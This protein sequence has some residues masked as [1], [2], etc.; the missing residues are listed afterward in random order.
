MTNKLSSKPFGSSRKKTILRNSLFS[1]KRSF[2]EHDVA[3]ANDAA[4]L[5]KCCFATL[6]NAL[7]HKERKANLHHSGKAT[8]S[9]LPLGKY[10][11]K[12]DTHRVSFLLLFFILHHFQALREYFL[13]PL[14]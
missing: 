13:N 8:A 11:I 14:R 10:I 1:M 9:Y 12:K 5:M 6:S 4:A 3:K 2:Q 7:L